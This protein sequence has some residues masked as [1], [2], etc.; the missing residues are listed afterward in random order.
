MKNVYLIEK[1]LIVLEI[2]KFRNFFLSLPHFPDSKRQMK[3]E[4]FIIS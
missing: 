3:M 4:Q 2:F 1:A